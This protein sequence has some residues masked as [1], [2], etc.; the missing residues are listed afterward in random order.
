[1]LCIMRW[2]YRIPGM[3]LAGI[4]AAAA[5]PVGPPPDTGICQAA[6]LQEQTSRAAVKEADII[7]ILVLDFFT[8]INVIKYEHEI[9]SSQIPQLNSYYNITVNNVGKTRYFSLRTF[10]YN[11]YGFRHYF[12]SVTVK[13]EDNFRFRNNIQVPLSPKFMLQA[14]IE[15]KTQLWRKWEQRQD[16]MQAN[17]RYLYTDYY[18]PGYT[19][20]SLG[21][22][23][24]FLEGAAVYL[25]LVGGKIT[26]IRNQRIF[27]DRGVSKLYGITKGERRIVEWGVNMLVSIPPQLLSRH[28]G[29]ELSASLFA[30]RTAIS[31]VRSYTAESSSVIHYMFLKHMRLSLRTQVQYDEAVQEK[32]FVANH[33]SLGFYLSNKL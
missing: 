19:I 27:D 5:Q 3:L 21:A 12:D 24:N 28:V 1:M 32:V 14:G 10:I 17:V 20:Y 22:G 9:E 8:T 13:T 11:E 23:L 29:W 26:R 4:H 15:Q 25:G 6:T 31:R 18:S 2:L 7:N 33:L 16:T 30:P